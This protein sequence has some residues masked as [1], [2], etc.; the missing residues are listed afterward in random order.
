VTEKQADKIAKQYSEYY[1]K[2]SDR[3]KDIVKVERMASGKEIV[4]AMAKILYADG[5]ADEAEVRLL[6]KTAESYMLPETDLSEIVEAARDGSLEV[7]ISDN[8]PLSLAIFQGM[9]EMA[10]ADGVIS[11]EEDAVLQDMAEKLNYDKYTFN[12]FIKKAENKS[13]RARRQGA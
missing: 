1:V 10:F 2:K 8:K 9:A 4:S 3:R 6:R 13:A 12:M 7:P 11:L 5:V